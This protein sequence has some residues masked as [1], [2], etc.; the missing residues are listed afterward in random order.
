MQGAEVSVG[1]YKHNDVAVPADMFFFFCDACAVF[2]RGVDEVFDVLFLEY[3]RQ[4]IHA[5]GDVVP[6]GLLVAIAGIRKIYGSALV[7]A[8]GRLCGRCVFVFLHLL[9]VCLSNDVANVKIIFKKSKMYV[10]KKSSNFVTSRRIFANIFAV[11]TRL[12]LATPCVTGMYSNQLNYQ[13]L[14]IF[15]K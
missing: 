12:E 9:A 14:L 6:F 10:Q 2:R 15:C 8:F 7:D 5:V 3:C 4:L 1:K 13:T 11:W